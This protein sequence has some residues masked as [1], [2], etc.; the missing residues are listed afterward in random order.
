[1]SWDNVFKL[2]ELID[3]IKPET[4]LDFVMLQKVLVQ[5]VP[6]LKE[7]ILSCKDSIY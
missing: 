4:V 2:K 7:L 1:M 3:K 6:L 5:K